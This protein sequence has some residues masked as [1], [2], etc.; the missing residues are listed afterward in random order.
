M[1]IQPSVTLEMCSDELDALIGIYGLHTL[2]VALL[3]LITHKT[4]SY[5]EPHYEAHVAKKWCAC[6]EPARA[7]ERAAL[8]SFPEV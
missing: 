6:I 1:E 4:D 7:L 2:T 3:D 8:K 5:A